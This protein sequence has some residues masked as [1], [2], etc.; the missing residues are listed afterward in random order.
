MSGFLSPSQ[1]LGEDGASLITV[2]SVNPGPDTVTSMH[3]S[4]F[5]RLRTTINPRFVP[6]LVRRLR[7]MTL[8]LL[9]VEVEPEGLDEPT[10]RV[11]TPQVIAAY[12]AAA[13][14]FVEAVRI[15]S[16]PFV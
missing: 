1:G 14:D 6:E 9:P 13:G 12:R 10:S 2:K 11:I 16:V 7:A 4:H 3:R 15:L 8:Q 5:H